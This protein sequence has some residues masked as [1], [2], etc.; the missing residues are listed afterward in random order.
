L[1]KNTVVPDIA[2]E[3]RQKGGAGMI[4]AVC[5]CIGQSDFKIKN[6][7]LL[8]TNHGKNVDPI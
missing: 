1:Q 7:E 2:S 5:F 4:S 6:I 3:M 8:E